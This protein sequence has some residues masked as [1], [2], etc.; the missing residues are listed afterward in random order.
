MQFRPRAIL[1]P[2]LAV[3]G[4]GLF[5]FLPPLSGVRTAT[6]TAILAPGRWLAELGGVPN[7]TTLDE[8]TTERN[9]LVRENAR[10]RSLEQENQEM[11]ELLEVQER[12]RF[13]LVAA[14]V[15]GK[16]PEVDTQTLILD[17]GNEDGIAKGMPVIASDGFLL[18]KIER[19][20]ARTAVVVLVSDSS[21]RVASTILNTERTLGFVEGGRGLGMSFRLIPQH[22]LI[23]PGDTVITSGLEHGIPRGL[24][25]GRVGRVS[26]EPQ[27]PFQ[28][29][30]VTQIVNPE[31]RQ[32]VA[33][34]RPVEGL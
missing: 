2:A 16:S 25:L 7:P 30:T 33:V 34:I 18:G 5:F 8:L 26:R 24:I 15:I 11:R 10:L 6:L 31:R 4:A 27:E 3:A 9:D 20:T 1:L 29:A 32:I 13:T 22:E 23:A 19:V 12:S 14:Q 17:R 28:T 21:S